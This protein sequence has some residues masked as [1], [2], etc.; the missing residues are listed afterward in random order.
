VSDGVYSVP[1]QLALMRQEN[2]RNVMS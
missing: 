2:R 1:V